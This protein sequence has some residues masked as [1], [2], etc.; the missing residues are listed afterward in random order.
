MKKL[1]M[2]WDV[3]H[4]TDE[5]RK[6]SFPRYQREPNV[7]SLAQKRR[8]IDSMLREFD[9]AALYFYDTGDGLVECVDGRQRIGTILSFLGLNEWDGQHNDFSFQVMNELHD[10]A[11]IY[12]SA[13][14]PFATLSGMTY[15][16]IEEGSTSDPVAGE[17]LK[18]LRD[19]KMTIVLLK[20]SREDL[21]FNLQFTRLNLGTLI[22][23]GEKLHAMVGDLRDRCFGALGKH[24]F[25]RSV[26]IRTR[27]FARE[28]L[29]AQMMAQV[30]AIEAGR[31]EEIADRLVRM[32]YEDLQ[33]L[34][35]QHKRL[36]EEEEKWIAKVASV[37]TEL[38][39]AFADP[40]V[41]R[42]QAM[43]LSVVLLAYELWEEEWFD[44]T[45]LAGF[46]DV[47][48]VRL[49]EQLQKGL[50]YEER[51]R[52]LIEFQRHV[53]QASVESAAV[54]SRARVLKEEF[55]WWRANGRVLRGDEA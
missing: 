37:M 1:I 9:I 33:K 2:Q 55:M 20:E 3:A 11:D 42:S 10:D 54:R 45:E 23:S 15:R 49:G 19:Y 18:A 47:L 5:F 30:A 32:R 17:F 50:D 53:T 41:F 26:R 4:L 25:L 48:L 43:V 38:G 21:E 22:N 36:T 27:R 14:H 51:Y 34:F 31:E 16:D 8:L 6:I 13:G 24:T 46:V 39:E 29:A 12:G 44:V 28:Q 7:W 52:Y 40:G 35:R